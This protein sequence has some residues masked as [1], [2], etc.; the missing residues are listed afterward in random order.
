LCE[1]WGNNATYEVDNETHPHEAYHLKLDCSKARAKLKWQ[2]KWNLEEALVKI[3]EWVH[4]YQEKKDILKACFN[5]I[6]EYM[7]ECSEG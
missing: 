1:K 7:E 6:Q 5:Q 2:P 4:A 3:I